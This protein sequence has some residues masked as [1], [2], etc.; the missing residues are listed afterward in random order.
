MYTVL[1][2]VAEGCLGTT[3]HR[4]TVSAVNSFEESRFSTVWLGPSASLVYR[5]DQIETGRCVQY[6]PNGVE[7]GSLCTDLGDRHPA[8]EIHPSVIVNCV[9]SY[10]RYMCSSSGFLFS[11]IVD[12]IAGA[13]VGAA[14]EPHA[15]G[16]VRPGFGDWRRALVQ[17]C[18][19]LEKEVINISPF[20]VDCRT[21]SMPA[22]G[23]R[24]A[25]CSLVSPF[26]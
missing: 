3:K 13:F 1:L 26:I 6:R 16:A 17:L 10:L 22:S 12:S 19:T 8:R 4:Q 2:C 21:R 23:N 11:W 14:M 24:F 15:A 18:W 20:S 7:L 25:D 9:Y 5:I